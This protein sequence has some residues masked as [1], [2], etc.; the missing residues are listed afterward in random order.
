MTSDALTAISLFSSAG[1]GDLGL[2]ANAFDVLTAN[3][4]LRDRGELYAYNHPDTLLFQG[5]IWERR[6]ELVQATRER[7]QGRELTLAY[8]T[9]PC[10]GMSTNGAGKLMAEVAAGNRPEEDARNRLIIP[11]MDIIC[12]LRPRWVVLENV[13]GM[14][15]T[16][17]RTEDNTYAKVLDYV[18]RRLG[19]AYVGRGEVLACSDYGV[20]QLRRRLISVFTRDAVGQRYFKANGDTFFPAGERQAPISLREAIGALPALDGRAGHNAAPDFHPLHVVNVLRPEKYMWVANTPEGETAFNNQCTEPACRYQGNARHVD[21]IEAGRM[22][23]SKATPIY[24]ERCGALLPRPTMLD[25]KTGQRRLIS[26][27]HSA[28]RRMLWDEPARALTSNF[29]FEASDNKI[30]PGQ[31][32]VL[33]IY[34]AMVIQTIANYPYAWK[35][36]RGPASKTLI[37]HVIG[38]SVPPRLIDTIAKKIVRLTDAAA[39]GELDLLA[40]SGPAQ[41]TLF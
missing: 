15:L 19:P 20:P 16:M 5:D 32:R 30:H 4:L 13:P 7:L 11:A 35:T 18:S 24:C 22:H 6:E 3:E 1:I 38:E 21:L 12:A 40:P 34:E 37:A 25:P 26:G 29:P 9:P 2:K 17:I 28:Y 10:Q 36:A 41:L 33:S 31:N 39:A 27:F 23:A 8:A 14:Q